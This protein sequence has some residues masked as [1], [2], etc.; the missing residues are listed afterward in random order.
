MDQRKSE[1]SRKRDQVD[2][3]SNTNKKTEGN[4]LQ[5]QQ[6]IKLL[7]TNLQTL[8]NRHEASVNDLSNTIRR[9]EQE[10]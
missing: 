2:S 5:I 3:L 4:V 1:N 9:L 6:E 10:N 7:E 8:R